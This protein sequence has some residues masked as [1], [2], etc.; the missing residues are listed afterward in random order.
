MA[1]ISK[2]RVIVSIQGGEGVDI[3][4]N[5]DK[6]TIR[7]SLGDELIGEIHYDDSNGLADT[8]SWYNEAVSI[9]FEYLG[10]S[11]H[12][13]FITD[14]IRGVTKKSSSKTFVIDLKA[15]NHLKDSMALCA[16]SFSGTATNVIKKIHEEFFDNDLLVKDEA[17][18]RGMFI[19]PNISPKKAINMILNKS[20]NKE[21]S[22]FMQFQHFIGKKSPVIINSLQNM[23][24]NDPVCNFTQLNS[25]DKTN[26]RAIM[27][28][29]EKLVIDGDVTAAVAKRAAGEFGRTVVGYNLEKQEVEAV[30]L[31]DEVNGVN[32]MIPF[33]NNMYNHREQPLLN[34]GDAVHIF[35]AKFV[36]SFL[37]QQT[38]SI[39]DCHPNHCGVGDTAE[40][41]VDAVVGDHD[42]P[43]EKYSGK[44]LIKGII[45]NII[46]DEFRQNLRMNKVE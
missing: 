13:T 37:N 4:K 20:Y 27:G 5:V 19:S 23:I 28:Q 7:E 15:V 18:N 46:G 22:P 3:T 21:D 2:Y 32:T 29:A 31:G 34:N 36:N 42:V 33:R 11:Y 45:H 38:M 14:G 1:N 30:A 39:Y 8:I 25:L 9:S 10:M 24:A 12:S 41:T 6:I 16:K 43:S 35:T 44:Y 26:L 40:I 17:L